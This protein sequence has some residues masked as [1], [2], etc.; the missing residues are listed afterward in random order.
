MLPKSAEHT[1]EEDLPSR[2][3]V[4][5]SDLGRQTLLDS[6]LVERKVEVAVDLA[7]LTDQLVAPEPSQPASAPAD[8]G[9]AFPA[10]AAPAV[11]V[12]SYYYQD[13]ALSLVPAIKL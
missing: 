8:P 7:V 2:R 13:T 4:L 3:T 5:D 12:D 1:L 6:D 10:L 11:L 9:P